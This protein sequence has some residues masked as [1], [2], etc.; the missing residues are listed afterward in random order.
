MRNGAKPNR[1]RLTVYKS[2][3]DK[4]IVVVDLSN[5]IS[6]YVTCVY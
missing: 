6:K 5:V 3:G 1:M 2:N 4:F